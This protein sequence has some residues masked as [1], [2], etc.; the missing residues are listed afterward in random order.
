VRGWLKIR[1]ANRAMIPAPVRMAMTSEASSHSDQWPT[2]G[3]YQVG[4][5]VSR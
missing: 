3:M 4:L 5:S 1:I 2:Q